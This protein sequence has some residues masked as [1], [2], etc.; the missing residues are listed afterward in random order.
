MELIVYYLLLFAIALATWFLRLLSP[1]GTFTAF[2]IGFVLVTFGG[3]GWLG[4]VLLF[5]VFS[6]IL[7]RF[8]K[9]RKLRVNNIVEKGGQS[10]DALQVFANSLLAVFLSLLFFLF[11]SNKELGAFISIAFLGAVATVCA[12]TAA[13]EIGVLSKK[14][15][16][17]VNDF[18][19]ARKGLSGGVSMQGFV[20]AVI[21]AAVIAL[22][23]LIFFPSLPM[24]QAFVAITFA[25]FI[26]SFADSLLGAMAQASYYCTKCKAFTEQ[27]VH[28]CMTKTVLVKGIPLMTNDA[29]NFLSSIVGALVAILAFLAMQIKL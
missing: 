11:N 13:T 27:D 5:F 19:E 10:R 2:I 15:P 21:G 9:K 8:N 17:M 25:G 28:Y 6:N 22:G 14:R 4:I 18:K 20:G 23:G 24:I 3:I 16:L 26:G 29:V 7:T 1:V 12:D